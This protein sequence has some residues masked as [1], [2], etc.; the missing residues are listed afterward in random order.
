MSLTWNKLTTRRL[1]VDATE[2]RIRDEIMASFSLD[3][4]KVTPIL[5]SGLSGDYRAW[6]IQFMSIAGQRT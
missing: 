1:S 4:V 5:L 3:N 6:D 2:Q